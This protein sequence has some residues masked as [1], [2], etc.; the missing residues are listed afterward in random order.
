MARADQ[1]E[2]LMT[3]ELARAFEQIERHLKEQ[4]D[5]Q[6]AHT[7]ELSNTFRKHELE[8][9]EVHTKVN[10]HLE[11]HKTYMT[12][13]DNWKIAKLGAVIAIIAALAAAWY[14]NHLDAESHKKALLEIKAELKK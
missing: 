11:D 1:A 14:S 5:K 12:Q 9:K 6:E 7:R 2:E 4:D 13:K 10:T 3:P 8:D